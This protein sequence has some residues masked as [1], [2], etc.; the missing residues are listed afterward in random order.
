MAE[1]AFNSVRAVQRALHLLTVLCPERQRATL[2]EFSQASGLATST[3]Q[4]LLQTLD[5]EH[6]LRREMDGSYT[7]GT[8]LIQLGLYALQGIELYDLG[9]PYLERLSE[10]TGETA[11]LGVLDELGK[12]LYI[13][14]SLSRQP[15]CHA[16]WLGRPFAAEGTAI[17]AVLTRHVGVYGTVATRQTTA[18][19]VTAVAAP[20]HDADG[21]ITAA[22]GVT[23]PTYRIADDDLERFAGLVA[24][25]ARA[26]TLQIG[27]H[28]P[29][30][31]KSSTQPNTEPP[32][33]KDHGDD[34]A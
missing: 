32:L 12:V 29:Y 21:D 23:G 10:Q 5:S 25:A 22:F 24:A 30:P 2:T 9:K 3:A 14:Q 19:D 28:W 13:R 34:D 16:S 4:R 18:P 6:F 15:I 7:F 26:A 11:N 8:A 17:G 27:G 1:S 20:I 33:I 31:Q